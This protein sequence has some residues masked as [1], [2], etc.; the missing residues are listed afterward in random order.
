MERKRQ[1]WSLTSLNASPVDEGSALDK[2]G[3]QIRAT[4]LKV[5]SMLNDER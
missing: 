4:G 5:L 3:E 2:S 1:N